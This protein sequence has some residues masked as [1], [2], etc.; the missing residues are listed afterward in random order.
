M[1]FIS[2]IINAISNGNRANLN[3]IIW[4]VSQKGQYNSI[5]AILTILRDNGIIRSFSYRPVLSQKLNSPEINEFTIYLK[6]DGAGKRVIRSIF[7]V[8]KP[9]RRVYVSSRSLWQPQSTSGF[10]VLATNYG[11]LTDAQARRY[12]VGGCLLFGVT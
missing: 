7:N 1:D 11:I 4:R 3:S 10:F 9:S 2:K 6:Y 12:N 8:S 5:F